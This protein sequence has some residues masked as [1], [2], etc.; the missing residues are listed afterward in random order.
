MKRIRV[1]AL[2]LVGGWS[3][4]GAW[5]AEHGPPV[6]LEPVRV[7]AIWSNAVV[8]V[9]YQR[10][11]DG[12]R[13]SMLRVESVR[14]KSAAARAGLEKGMEIVA[15]QG[16]ALNGLTEE[17]YHHVMR[18]PVF[19]AFVLRVRREGRARTEDLRIPITK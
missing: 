1:A 5:G 19:D 8:R 16:V 13:I 4:T 9:I 14:E 7:A 11:S 3:A 17:D 15:I 12:P 10:S 2:I 6:T 18:T